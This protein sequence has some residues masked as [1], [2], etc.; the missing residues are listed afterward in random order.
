MAKVSFKELG[1]DR[2]YIT[3][4]MMKEMGRSLNKLPPKSGIANTPPPAVAFGYNTPPGSYQVENAGA[5]IV[6]GQVGPEGI[7]SGW[8]GQ[9]AVAPTVDIVVGRNA[10]ARAGKGPPEKTVVENNFATDA[11]RVY[12]SR[13]TDLDLYFGLAKKDSSNA[14][15]KKAR[16]GVGIKADNVA[17]IGREGVKIVT[18]PM[19]GAKFG[20]FGETNSL[21]GKISSRAP[22]IELIAGN[23]YQ[24]VQGV[25]LG[26]STRD[27]LRE[28]HDIVQDLLGAVYNF[29]TL[30]SSWDGV[31][32]V[33]PLPHH[34]A[35][36]APKTMGNLTMVMSSLYSS[37]TN[38]M[39]WKFNTLSP[40]GSSYIVSR[41]V[42]SN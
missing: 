15:S 2:N 30:Q 13:L 34:A 36:A 40:Y 32:G 42:K 10:S 18:G 35:G 12:V 8:G 38:L 29:I 9:G 1:L 27:S 39:L 23:N 3:V 17:V 41:N 24:G 11:A 19:S 16:S 22:K 20:P 4:E 31:L 37:R 21:G 25:A 6:A 28:L 14:G 7:S 33:T 26:E 5:Y